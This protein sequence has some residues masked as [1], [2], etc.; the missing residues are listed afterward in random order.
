MISWRRAT[1]PWTA[2]A[3]GDAAAALVVVALFSC[4]TIAPALAQEPAVPNTSVSKPGGDVGIEASL[5]ADFSIGAEDMLSVLVWREKDLSL[6][7]AVR[8]D[9]YIT[10]P[11]V[12]DVL[13]AGK[14]PSELRDHLQQML[15]AHIK[16]PNVTV[17]VREIKSRK[18][19]ITGKIVRPGAYPLLSPMRVMDLIAVAGGLMP[20]A[21]GAHVSVLRND[22]GARIS[23]PIDYTQLLRG[24]RVWQ[25]VLLRPGDTIVVP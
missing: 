11:L 17:V 18:V 20:S 22:K 3:R 14:T 23:L 13:A 24:Q 5:P 4:A 16:E 8:P 2:P 9:G 25:D 19:F 1:G 10:L 12:N 21:D 6:D 15:R 7:V